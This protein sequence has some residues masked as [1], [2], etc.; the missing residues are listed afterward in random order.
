MIS[1]TRPDGS[2]H[3]NQFSGNIVEAA[4]PGVTPSGEVPNGSVIPGTV[5][6]RFGP[7]EMPK[8][9]FDDEG[10]PSG[11]PTG[12]QDGVGPHS[13]VADRTWAKNAKVICKSLDGNVTNAVLN[14]TPWEI[15]ATTGNPILVL[16][17][18]I[19]A[20]P[21]SVDIHVTIPHTVVR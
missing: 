3:F 16:D 17:M 21:A 7:L 5:S 8:H 6:V 19:D 10:T 13:T 15:D 11:Y 2:Q 14:A 1:P 4:A 18:S 20:L 12:S 9:V